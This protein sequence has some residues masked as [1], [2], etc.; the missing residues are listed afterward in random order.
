MNTSVEGAAQQIDASGER[1]APITSNAPT[2][3]TNLLDVTY[4][5]EEDP[6]ATKAEVYSA[7]DTGGGLRWIGIGGGD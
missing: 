1:D 6:S 5:L 2:K 3:R 7:A 4:V